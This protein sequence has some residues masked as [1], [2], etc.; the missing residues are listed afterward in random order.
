MEVLD[1]THNKLSEE[2]LPANFWMMGKHY[3]L[4]ARSN[5]LVPP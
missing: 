5:L 1:L 4:A 2:S 3:M